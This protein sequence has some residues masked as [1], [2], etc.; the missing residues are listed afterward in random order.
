[1]ALALGGTKRQGATRRHSDT[2]DAGYTF[3]KPI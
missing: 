1:M 2:G 3:P